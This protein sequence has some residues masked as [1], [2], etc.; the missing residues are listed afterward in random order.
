MQPG[1][2]IKL[3]II[4]AVIIAIAFLIKSAFSKKDTPTTPVTEKRANPNLEVEGYIVTA[5]EINNAIEASGSL[6]S[7]ESIDLK[8]EMSGRITGIY[9]KEGQYVQKN[10]LLVKLFDGD[11]K[12]QIGKLESQKALAAKTLERQEA[13]LKI[14]AISQQELDIS[15][16]QISVY[17]ADIDYNKA[18]LLRTEIRAPFSGIIGIRNI[19]EGAI[20]AQG[21]II[22]TLHQNNP[23]K[24]DFT[25]PEKYRPLVNNN[26]YFHFRV[27]GDTTRY[28][29][30]VYVI[31]P[32]IDMA[33]R[34]VKI[35][36]RVNNSAGKLSPGTFANVSLLLSKTAQA[37]MVPSQAIIPGTRDKKIVISK[38]GVAQFVIVQTGLRTE[39]EVEITEGLQLGDTV[40]ISGL[41]QVK[42]G[43]QV[44]FTNLQNP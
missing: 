38:N 7:N 18:L 19:S 3:I 41:M 6:L 34:S 5:S 1:K 31:D 9:F 27:A 16:N 33:T 39:K 21:N 24:I 10:A 11:I 29:G 26:D 43:R 37:L 22:A 32:Q 13:L 30:Q 14:A 40:L 36:G 28:R 42:E 12:A 17:N 35:R 2:L 15:S 23:L 8:P 20:V 4:L 44:S 25:L